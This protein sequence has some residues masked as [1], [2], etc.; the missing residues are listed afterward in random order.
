ME[1]S[2][3]MTSK[4]LI[5]LLLASISDGF[6]GLSTLAQ[7]AEMIEKAFKNSESDAL[8]EINEKQQKK[9]DKLP[10]IETDDQSYVV[11]LKKQSDGAYKREAHAKKDKIGQAVEPVLAPVMTSAEEKLAGGNGPVDFDFQAGDKKLYAVIERHGDCLVF[12]ICPTKDEVEG[13][14]KAQGKADTAVKPTPAPEPKKEEKKE[15]TKPAEAKEEPKKEETK[16][17]HKEEK[18]AASIVNALASASMSSSAEKTPEAPAV[19]SDAKETPAAEAKAPEKAIEAAVPESSTIDT[20]IP[21]PIEAPAEGSVA[22][23]A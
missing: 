6:A 17:E 21:K 12:N 10:E 8:K 16:V 19:G 18:P 23:A 20:K 15:E 7:R 5:S 9:D 2:L 4:I 13:F 22:A 1:I 14:L 11:V 3:V